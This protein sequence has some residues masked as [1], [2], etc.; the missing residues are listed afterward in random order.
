MKREDA[1]QTLVNLSRNLEESALK[2]FSTLLKQ[3]GGEEQK[4]ALLERYRREYA[5]RL[6]AQKHSGIAA[7]SM[8][9]FEQ[10][11]AHL[12][13]ALTQQQGHATRSRAALDD[14]MAALRE[15]RIRSKV[16]QTLV[17]RRRG[18]ARLRE[19]RQRQ[20][21]EDEFASRKASQGKSNT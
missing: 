3:C 20:K 2:R 8:E 21:I 9:N 12:E 15:A 4:L 14:G 19:D 7:P 16:F 1:T 5:E 10:F 11:I 13:G 6:A 18:A 17:E